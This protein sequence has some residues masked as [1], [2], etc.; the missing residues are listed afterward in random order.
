MNFTRVIP[1]LLIQ[2]GGLVKTVKFKNPN[3]V[4]DP[5]NAV[6]IFNVKEVDELILFDISATNEGREPNYKE[7]EEIVSEAFMPIGYGGGINKIDHIEKLF[8]IGVEKIILNSAA[9]VN[10]HLISEASS[11]YGSQSIVVNLDYK[12]D[13]WGDYKFY[14][15]SGSQKILSKCVDVIKKMED[16]GA[17]EIILNSIDKDGTMTGYDLNLFEKLA[18]EVS[19]PVIASGGAGSIQDFVKAINS[20]ASAVAAGSMFVYH[21]IHRAVLISYLQSKELE[22]IIKQNSSS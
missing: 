7:I 13:L 4:G 22:K 6:R 17:G 21:G 5:I 2:N 19:V 9:F 16:L 14:I 11:I 18:K 20:G 10:E 15:R 1:T 8:K 3:Y 12:K